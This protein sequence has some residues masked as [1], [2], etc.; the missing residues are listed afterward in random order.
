MT[1]G[2]R[3]RETRPVAEAE[4]AHALRV[5]RAADVVD[6]MT[7]AVTRNESNKSQKG[8]MGAMKLAAVPGPP[9]RKTMGDPGVGFALRNR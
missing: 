6:V 2:M 7:S 9:I 4:E 5:K 1:P 8:G 3:H